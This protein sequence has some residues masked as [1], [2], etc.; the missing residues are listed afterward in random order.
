ME[1]SKLIRTIVFNILVILTIVF[2]YLFF[3]P[4]KSYI[5]NKIDNGVNPIVDETFNENIYSMKIAGMAYFENKENG[6]ATIQELIDNGLLADLKDSTQQSCYASSY[7]EKIDDKM[8][9]HLECSDKSGEKFISLDDGKFLCIYQYEKKTEN[10]FTSWSDWSDWSTNFVESNELTN[11]ETEVRKELDGT[12]T[13]T[14]AKEE[15]VSAYSTANKTKTGSI[16]A[17]RKEIYKNGQKYFSFTCPA[18]TSE[19]EYVLENTKC[20][21]YTITRSNYTCPDGYSLSGTTCYRTVNYDVETENYK[22]VTYYRYQKREIIDE[23]I[24]IKWS[25]IDDQNLLNDSYTM[26]GKVSC[27][28]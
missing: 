18:N 20:I 22:D 24:D 21:V 19:K 1:N 16:D 3:F 26:V 2:V 15:T 11:V 14:E 23:K 5:K 4:K 27:E 25:T 8:K 9:I 13:K 28:F 10:S 17:T 7:V 6:T 12:T